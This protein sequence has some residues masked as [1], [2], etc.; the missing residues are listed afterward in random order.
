M[1]LTTSNRYSDTDLPAVGERVVYAPQ[2]IN[3]K[4]AGVVKAHDTRYR[5]TR[6]VVALGSGIEATV[7][8]HNLF[9]EK[10]K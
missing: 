10:T 9:R 8:P 3:L 7:L 1:I 5:Q 2:G 4:G 6:L